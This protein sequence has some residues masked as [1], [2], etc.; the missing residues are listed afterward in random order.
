MTSPDDR[1]GTHANASAAGVD[2]TR[3]N[4]GTTPVRQGFGFDEAALARWME[5]NV[6][7][8]TGPL[9]VEQFKG[10]QSNP[11][12]PWARLCAPSQAT[13]RPLTGCPCG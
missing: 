8:F 1:V 12:Y 10:G 6:E 9:T 5:Q 7:G 2:F 4:S 11:T 3:A 13:W